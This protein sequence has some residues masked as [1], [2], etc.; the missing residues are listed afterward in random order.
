MKTLEE[1]EPRTTVAQSDLPF[2]ITNP[3]SYVVLEHLSVTSGIAEATS[4]RTNNVTIR[5]HAMG[6]VSA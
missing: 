4:I 6:R 2:A 5:V 3:W 1:V